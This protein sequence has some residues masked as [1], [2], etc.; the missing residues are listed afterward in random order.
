MG[1]KNHKNIPNRNEF[2]KN[3]HAEPNWAHSEENPCFRF[4][5]FIL[6]Y[7]EKGNEK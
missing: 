4:S 6:F 5:N 1:P 3:A 2:E 7:S